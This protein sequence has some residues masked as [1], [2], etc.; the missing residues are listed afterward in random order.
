MRKGKR[1]FIFLIYLLASGCSQNSDVDV[2]KNAL[3]KPLTNTL[4][5]LVVKTVQLSGFQQLTV[6]F[7]EVLPNEDVIADVRVINDT[8]KPLIPKDIKKDCGC[9]SVIMPDKIMPEQSG[10]IRIQVIPAKGFFETTVSF[11]S[12]QTPEDKFSIKLLGYTK[13]NAHFSYEEIFLG[14]IESEQVIECQNIF[15]V[16]DK[17]KVEQ[18]SFETEPSLGIVEAKILHE[19][20]QEII[21]DLQYYGEAQSDISDHQV[22]VRA[23]W[24]EEGA[25]Q[26]DSYTI[27]YRTQP[28]KVDYFYEPEVISFGYIKRDTGAERRFTLRSNGDV[29]IIVERV[30]FDKDEENFA[31]YIEENKTLTPEI[32]VIPVFRPGINF[33]NLLISINAPQKQVIRIP[34]RFIGLSFD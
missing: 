33:S 28:T 12:Y 6:D 31:V 19:A 2:S 34:C 26:T 29:P 13:Y 5:S 16:P 11:S 30:M 32:H 18:L 7:E 20:E 10:T 9:L 15:Y 23:S 4:N 22:Y 8:D 24:I 14:T 25:S 21:Y 27:F 17:R 1:F 3:N